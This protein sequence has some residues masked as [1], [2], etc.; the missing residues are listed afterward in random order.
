MNWNRTAEEYLAVADE[1]LNTLR[2]PTERAAGELADCL[3]RGGKILVCGN[4]GSAADAQHF[5]GELV[6]RFLRERR[7]YA[8]VALSTDT[9]VLTSIGNDYGF[10]QV[11][12]KQVHALGRAGDI[13]LAFSTSGNAV[14]VCRA[15]ETARAAGLRTIAVTGGSGG[16]LAGLADTLLT[17]SCTRLTPRIQE[18]HLLILHALAE[19]LE[20]ILQ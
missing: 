3:R 20:E 17:V 1:V 16:R 8:A 7:P 13:L 11:F 9:S 14:N 10:E 18:G 19:R 2:E 15:V 4:G 6:N 12:E 5:A